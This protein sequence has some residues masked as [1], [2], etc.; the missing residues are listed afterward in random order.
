MSCLPSNW[1]GTVATESM[2]SSKRRRTAPDNG[3]N[4]IVAEF[5]RDID[6][7]EQTHDSGNVITTLPRDVLFSEF[8][9]L[10]EL[11][12]IM[13]NKSQS[14]PVVTRVYEESFMRECI[15]KGEKPCAMGVNCECMLLDLDQPFVG[16]QFVIP[17]TNDSDFAANNL[18]II[19]LRKTTQL[20]FHHVVSQGI[21]TTSLI[22]KYGNICGEPG[23]YSKSAMLICPANGPV[24]CMPLPIVAH[25]RNRYAVE[26]RH[27]VLYAKQQRVYF[28]DF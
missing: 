20:L 22:Q 27:N 24:G 17:F 16:V 11:A 4:D 19:C 23:E 8:S 14:V 15:R 9:F 1:N 28:E 2:S 13:E 26:R 5:C 3:M 25:Q 7:A 18:C 6:H 10:H 21:P 12:D